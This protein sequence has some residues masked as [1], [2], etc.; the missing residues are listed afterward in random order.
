MDLNFSQIIDCNGSK[1]IKWSKYAM[2]IDYI[3]NL[4]DNENPL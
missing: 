2:I 4:F 3:G 1:S